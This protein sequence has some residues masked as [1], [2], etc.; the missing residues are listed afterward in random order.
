MIARLGKWFSV[1]TESFEYST[2][3]LHY[4]DDQMM[5]MSPQAK[6]SFCHN[7]DRDQLPVEEH[8]PYDTLRS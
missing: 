8:I 2:R 7:S 4:F 1:C 3:I 5:N 6:A